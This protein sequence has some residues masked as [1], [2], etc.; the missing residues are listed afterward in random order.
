MDMLIFVCFSPNFKAD[1]REKN[2]CQRVHISLELPWNIGRVIQQF[3]RT[4][5]SNQV[6]LADLH[7]NSNR[8][9]ILSL[10]CL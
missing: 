6:K 9:S 10:P 3:G 2:Q 7:L 5:R 1:R 8:Y 4:H